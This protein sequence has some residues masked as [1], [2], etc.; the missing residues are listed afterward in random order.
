MGPCNIVGLIMWGLC[1]FAVGFQ[2]GELFRTRKRSES[3]RLA[4]VHGR[5]KGID[6]Y[7][8]PKPPPL[9]FPREKDRDH[10]RRRITGEVE[11]QKW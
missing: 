5:Q 2:P 3:S 8:G 6:T 4:V 9:T 7:K 1:P 11:M 10:R